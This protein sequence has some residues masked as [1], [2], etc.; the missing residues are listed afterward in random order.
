MCGG[1]GA[2]LTLSLRPNGDRLLIAARDH[3]ALANHDHPVGE[4]RTRR[5]SL[6]DPEG[7]PAR[8]IRPRPVLHHPRAIDE[9]LTLD[10]DALR[11]LLGPDFSEEPH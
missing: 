3:L 1:Y 11:A 5:H 2:T 6:L 9:H 4:G 7:I 8:L 10:D